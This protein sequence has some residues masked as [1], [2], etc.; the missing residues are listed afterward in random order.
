M[1]I[2]PFYF[3]LRELLG[4]LGVDVLAKKKQQVHIIFHKFTLTKGMF[5]IAKINFLKHDKNI[6]KKN[7]IFYQVVIKIMCHVNFNYY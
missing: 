6:W 1:Y 2:H 4:K 7:T 5:S 3:R